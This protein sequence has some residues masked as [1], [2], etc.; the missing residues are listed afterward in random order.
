MPK[1]ENVY[2]KNRKITK[3]WF[4]SNPGSAKHPKVYKPVANKFESCV[5]VI[6]NFSKI[7]EK[8]KR[9]FSLF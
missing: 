7:S 5:I 1:L 9:L 6:V 3:K 4:L 8:E 2:K